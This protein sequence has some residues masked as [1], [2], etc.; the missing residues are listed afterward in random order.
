MRWLLVISAL[1]VF[2]EACGGG[3]SAA[4]PSITAES[5]SSLVFAT[6]TVGP[7]MTPPSP[8]AV[9]DAS[10]EVVWFHGGTKEKKWMRFL[11]VIH[12]SSSQTVEGLEARWDVLDA[13]GKVL[14]TQPE[15]FVAL[16]G[17]SYH[18][19]MT[20]SNMER[21]P[22]SVEMT[23]TKPGRFTSAA[24]PSVLAVTDIV[25]RPTTSKNQYNV[26]ALI[27][28]GSADLDTARLIVLTVGRDANGKVVGASFCHP[29]N[30]PARVPANTQF[31]TES[32]LDAP[33]G[34][35]VTVEVYAKANLPPE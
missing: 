35:P 2:A 9:P 18:S 29:N 1:G 3:N 25:M 5:T 4:R 16:P 15:T 21:P 33:D 11:A 12:N 31:K 26:T 23:L 20:S 17:D 13:G 19:W 14:L 27:S 30:I 7:T 24:P 28:S 6:A 22:A 10:V 34:V 32:C 8:T